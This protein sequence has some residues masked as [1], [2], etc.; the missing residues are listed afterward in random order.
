VIGFIEA[1][2]SFNIIETSSNSFI[3]KF[4]ITQ[5][6]YIHILVYIKHTFNIT[7][8][9]YSNRGINTLETNRKYSYYNNTL[10][11]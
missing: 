1:E 10:K 7:S 9:I 5:L 3:N 11:E 6:L 2:G 8:T 4:S